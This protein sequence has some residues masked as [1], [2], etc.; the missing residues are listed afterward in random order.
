MRL[1]GAPG[2]APGF[3]VIKEF[4]GVNEPRYLELGAFVAR[5]EAAGEQ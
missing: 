3:A 5:L 2:R 1:E 4:Y